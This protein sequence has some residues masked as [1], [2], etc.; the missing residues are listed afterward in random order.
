MSDPLEES[1][2]SDDPPTLHADIY[3]IKGHVTPDDVPQH[4]QRLGMSGTATAFADDAGPE[5]YEA[6]QLEHPKMDRSPR[7]GYFA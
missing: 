7:I 1:S 5:A 4:T 3:G 2:S 6:N